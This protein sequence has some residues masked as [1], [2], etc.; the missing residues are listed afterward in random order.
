MYALLE[1]SFSEPDHNE[2]FYSVLAEGALILGRHKPY[3]RIEYATRPEYER[4]GAAGSDDF[5]RY[6]HDDTPIG[7]TRWLIGT[8]GYGF[9]ALGRGTSLRPFAE[10]T[11]HRVAAERGAA[12][13]PGIRHVENL[14]VVVPPAVEG[15]DEDE[16][17]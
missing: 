9:T 8:V 11:Y 15:V 6:H 3:A 14:I 1:A 16:I 5:Y 13:A 2:G 12:S 10:A 4:L 7:A 17:C